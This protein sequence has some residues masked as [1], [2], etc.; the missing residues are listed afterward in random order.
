MND[1]TGS[2]LGPLEPLLRDDEVQEIMVDGPDRVYIERHG[3]FEDLPDGFRDETHLMEVIR[4]LIEPLGYR[5][6]AEQPFVDARLPDGAR[7]HVVIPPVSLNGPVLVV[8]K[9]WK[10]HLTVEDLISFGA[11]NEEIVEFLRACVRSRLNILV[12]GGTASGKT[13]M[14]NRIADMIPEDERIIA[15]QNA[16]E[17]ALSH[18]R[19]VKLETRLPDREGRGGVTAADLVWHALRMRP[20]RIVLGEIMDG[21]E[22]LLLFEAMN[23]GHE[24][25]LATMHAT[26]P[27]DALS[28]LEM[29]ITSANPSM[30]LLNVR[31][32]M[33]SALHLIVDQERLE[34][35]TRR[36]LRLTEVVGM[37]GDAILT[38]DVF[39]FRRTGIEDGRITGYF[40]ATGYIPSFLKRIR[41]AGIALPM[42]LFT[43]C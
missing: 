37:Q 5:V 27:R 38:Q 12:G 19:V 35:G 20:D 30:P 28:R 11:W 22:A 39:E 3:R 10:R 29:M 6:D 43:P 33:A 16:A 31:Q 21:S 2:D 7:V 23:R 36:V 24:G 8:R 32:V 34:D 9:F 25:T 1:R 41:E 15:I 4:R 13:T 26:G 17:L 42:S 14:L 18:R 40:T